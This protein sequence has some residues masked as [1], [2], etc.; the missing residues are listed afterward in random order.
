MVGPDPLC[1]ACLSNAEEGR[2]E[3]V[4]TLLAANAQVDETSGVQK[5]TPL[6]NASY[7]GH[8]DIV[9]VLLAAGPPSAPAFGVC[10]DASKL[11]ATL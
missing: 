9:A 8:A 5:S 7:M 10:C 2:I 11:S 3:E 6:F 1:I 4:E